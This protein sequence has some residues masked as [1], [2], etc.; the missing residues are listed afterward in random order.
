MIGCYVF[1]LYRGGCKVWMVDDIVGCV[2][3]FNFGL[4]G[5]VIYRDLFVMVCF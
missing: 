2:Y 4:I 1:L 3:M 5:F